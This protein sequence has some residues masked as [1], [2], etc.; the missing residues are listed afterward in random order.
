MYNLLTV[1]LWIFIMCVSSTKMVCFDTNTYELIV[2]EKKRNE[3]I[4]SSK[5][6]V[7]KKIADNIESGL[8]TPLVSEAIFIDEIIPK[9]ERDKRLKKY[10]PIVDVTSN[11]SRGG[12]INLNVSIKPDPSKV[13]S[14]TD[15]LFSR[16]YLDCALLKGF[17]IL[18]CPRWI[19]GRYNYELKPL[20]FLDNP[21]GLSDIKEQEIM[22]S[23]LVD[24]EELIIDANLANDFAENVDRESLASCYAFGVNYFCTNDIAKN[25]GIG[26]IMHVDYKQTIKKDFLIDIITPEV[27]LD[28]LHSDDCICS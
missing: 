1:G 4:Y 6:F 25:A 18:R 11:V 22:Y 7:Y 15:N 14:F 17:K 10:L 21:K 23:F 9:S 3:L 20:Y 16:E 8:I 2:S 24:L 27:L 12:N 26:S 19:G 28:M 5:S 13:P